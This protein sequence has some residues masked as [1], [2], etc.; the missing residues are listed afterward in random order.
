MKQT[1]KQRIYY[2]AYLTGIVAIL[3]SFIWHFVSYSTLNSD[4]AG[5]IILIERF[6]K[7]QYVLQPSDLSPYMFISALCYWIWGV[8]SMTMYVSFSISIIVC[9]VLTLYIMTYDN[10]NIWQ[11]FKSAMILLIFI[12]ASSVFAV[13]QL[14]YHCGDY[15]SFLAYSAIY[16]RTKKKNDVKTRDYIILFI[17]TSYMMFVSDNLIYCIFVVPFLL[18]VLVEWLAENRECNIRLNGVVLSGVFF[19]GALKLVYTKIWSNTDLGIQTTFY[20]SLQAKSIKGIGE[21]VNNAVTGIL[22]LFNADF[23]GQDLMSVNVILLMVKCI[24]LLWCL[25]MLIKTIIHLAKGKKVDEAVLASALGICI[26]C[27]VAIITTA[28]YTVSATRYFAMV[29][30]WNAI[31]L[32]R[33]KTDMLWINPKKWQGLVC[34]ILLFGGVGCIAITTLKWEKREQNFY[35]RLIN[36]ITQYDLQYGFGTFWNC[37]ALYLYSDGK[38]KLQ[39]LASDD[40]NSGHLYQYG[41]TSWIEDDVYINYVIVP[42]QWKSDHGGVSRSMVVSCFGKPV[43]EYLVEDNYIMVYDYNL[44]LSEGLTDRSKYSSKVIYTSQTL[45]KNKYAHDD[46]DGNII[47][48]KDGCQ[49]GPYDVYKKGKYEVTIRGEALDVADIDCVSKEGEEQVPITIEEVSNESVRYI[50]DIEDEV[51]GVEFRTRNNTDGTTITVSSIVVKK[52]E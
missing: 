41:V 46:W 27:A 9:V 36:D 48:E 31:I 6:L 50:I 24:L 21:S 18:I 30:Y 1:R 43:E 26:L 14:K 8:S 13:D 34:S 35:E 7:H 37:G 16:L 3:G 11:L 33:T 51:E 29:V 19:A 40:G 39:P 17:V 47:L 49:Y 38:I 20:N 22:G 32:A 42:K 5:T 15:I 45:Q 44:K 23:F 4:D 12:G 10:Q 2:V 52:I 25:A 28:F